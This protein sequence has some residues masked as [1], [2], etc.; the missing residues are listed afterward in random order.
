MPLN[1]PLFGALFCPFLYFGRAALRIR[2]LKCPHWD[3]AG[4]SLVKFSFV[5]GLS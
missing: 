3:L 5:F 2:M 1:C 4:Y